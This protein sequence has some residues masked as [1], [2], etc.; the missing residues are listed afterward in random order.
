MKMNRMKIHFWKQIAVVVVLLFALSGCLKLDTGSEQASE[1][2]IVL[3]IQLDVKEDIGLLL[4]DYEANGTQGSGGTSNADKSLLKHDEQ[5]TYSLCKQ[6]FENPL[7]AENL[8]IRFSIVTEYVDPN[9]E[10]RYPQE[11]TKP[12]EPIFLEAR[13]GQTYCITIT[14]DQTYGYQAI[15]NP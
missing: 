5:I 12:M 7:D 1:D 15:V 2:A 9:Y 3:Q 8:Q 11:L 10:N 6:D 4:V 14:G 13:F